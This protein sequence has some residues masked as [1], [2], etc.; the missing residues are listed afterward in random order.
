MGENV[1]RRGSRG[2]KHPKA[3]SVPGVGYGG[4]DGMKGTRTGSRERMQGGPLGLAGAPGRTLTFSPSKEESH[5]WRDLSSGGICS[6]VCFK[7]S[8]LS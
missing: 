1:P 5:Y 6:D 2:S 3:R 8:L 7:G 4:Q